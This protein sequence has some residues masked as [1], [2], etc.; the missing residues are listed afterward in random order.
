M[1]FKYRKK[2][3]KVAV[4]EPTLLENRTIIISH[5]YISYKKRDFDVTLNLIMR[6]TFPLYR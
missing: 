3:G 4:F 6:P 1:M 5:H 2:N